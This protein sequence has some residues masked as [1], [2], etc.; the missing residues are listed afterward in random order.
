MDGWGT[1]CGRDKKARL[2][3]KAHPRQTSSVDIVIRILD[4]CH[5]FLLCPDT[6]GAAFQ[7]CFY[8]SIC[9]QYTLQYF[10]FTKWVTSSKMIVMFA[11]LV[12]EISNTTVQHFL[13]LFLV[14]RRARRSLGSAVAEPQQSTPPA[15]V[16]RRPTLTS[17]PTLAYYLH[18]HL[19]Y[20]Y[21]MPTLAYYLLF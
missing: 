16:A 3:Q 1:K 11:L 17:I 12:L 20:T 13:L 15:V 6:L 14:L 2:A 8:V 4:T 5:T 21:F 9:T 7:I 18:L 10:V 19:T